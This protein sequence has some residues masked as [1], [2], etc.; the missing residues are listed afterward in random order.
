MMAVSAEYCSVRS[1]LPSREAH[2]GGSTCLN[3]S[4]LFS[5]WQ[6]AAGFDLVPVGGIAQG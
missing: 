1:L 4:R 2:V 6:W 3:Q 5:S